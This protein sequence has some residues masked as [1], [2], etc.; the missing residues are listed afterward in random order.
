MRN[1]L[2][3][4]LVPGVIAVVLS[5]AGSAAS[6]EVAGNLRQQPSTTVSLTGCLSATPGPSGQFGFVDADTGSTYRLTGRDV[7]KFAGQRA[8][9]VVGSSANAVTIRGGLWPSPNV[10][11]QAGALDSAQAAVAS[12]EPTNVAPSQGAVTELRVAHVRG[13][14][15]TCR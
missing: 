3:K 1:V 10:A 15:G 9:I 12:R 7:R 14:S 8:Q 13:L 4:T 6:Q 2:S 5:T 11:A